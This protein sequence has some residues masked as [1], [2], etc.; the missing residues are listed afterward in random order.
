MHV[1]SVTSAPEKRPEN[2]RSRPGQSRSLGIGATRR[3][4]VDLGFSRSTIQ[5]EFINS[6]D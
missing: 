1:L 3:G 5:L 6:G 4:T 2:G